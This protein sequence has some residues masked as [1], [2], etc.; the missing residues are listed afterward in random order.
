MNEIQEDYIN[1]GGVQHDQDFETCV[2]HNYKK[3][4]QF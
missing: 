1:N 4:L 2:D 3:K